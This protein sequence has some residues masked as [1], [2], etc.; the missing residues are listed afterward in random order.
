MASSEEKMYHSNKS[1]IV[2]CILN[3]VCDDEN[4]STSL[5]WYDAVIH[6]GG[7]LIHSLTPRG[8]RTFSDYA[9]NQMLKLIRMELRK[10]DIVWDY[11]RK[12]AIKEQIRGDRGKGSRLRVSPKT[13]IPKNWSEFLRDS[14]NKTELIHFLAKTVIEEDNGIGDV[15][16]TDVD[17]CTVR[18]VGTG[19]EMDG[20]FKQEEA[21]VRIVIH[22]LH[23]LKSFMQLHNCK[24]V[25]FRCYDNHNRPVLPIPRNQ[26][27]FPNSFSV[28]KWE[29]EKNSRHWL[30]GKCTGSHQIGCPPSVCHN[31]G[32]GHNFK[33]Q[34]KVKEDL[35]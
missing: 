21:D 32:L 18:H 17:N 2:E 8:A 7:A 1:A 10:V 35:F 3:E 28:W 9:F 13:L 30:N 16:M 4:H 22:I 12:Y 23:A 14:N 11:Y 34:R 26:R 31:D 20:E 15:Y 6:D 27:R 29:K 33:F 19:E 24:D 25:R 5:D